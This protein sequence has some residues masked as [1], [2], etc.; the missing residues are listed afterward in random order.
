MLKY[1]IDTW[2]LCKIEKIKEGDDILNHMHFNYVIYD[3]S[4]V[5]L[6]MQRNLKTHMTHM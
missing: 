1:W 6:Q 2:V 3:P 5:T 4:S